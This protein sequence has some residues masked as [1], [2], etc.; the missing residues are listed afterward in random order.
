MGMPIVEGG[1][2]QTIAASRAVG[3]AS[4]YISAAAWRDYRDAIDE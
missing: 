2:D 3:L 1:E 4:I